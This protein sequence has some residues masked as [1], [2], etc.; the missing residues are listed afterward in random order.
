METING[1]ITTVADAIIAFTHVNIVTGNVY[2]GRKNSDIL[3]QEAMLNNWANEW[4][5]FAQARSAGYKVL[6]GSKATQIFGACKN[7]KKSEK[8]DKKEKGESIYFKTVNVFN[9]A[10][11]EKME[12]KVA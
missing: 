1:N 6:K 8:V 3:T 2:T 11:L 7:K 10:Q 5:T 4:A 9:V 12:G